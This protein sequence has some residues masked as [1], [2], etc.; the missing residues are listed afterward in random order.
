LTFFTLFN[1][2]R[3][4][5]LPEDENATTEGVP[6]VNNSIATRARLTAGWLLSLSLATGAVAADILVPQDAGTI[7]DAIA[8]AQDGDRV[9]VAPGTYR[10]RIDFLGKNITVEATG[11]AAVT[12]IDGGGEVGHVVT[13][14]G[15]ETRDAV[16]RGFTI[17]GGFGEAGSNGAGPGGG[18]LIDAASPTLE[19]CVIT[20]NAGIL[21]G[22][23][24]A[25][26]GDALIRNT[27]FADNTGLHGGALY[28]EGGALTV[29]QSEFATNYATNYGGAVAAFWQA[30]VTLTDTDFT[31]NASGQFGG[32]FY[33]VHATVD[34]ARVTFLENGEGQFDADGN[35]WQLNTLGGG[36]VYTSNTSGRIEA[37]RFLRNLAAFGSSIYVAGSGTLEVVNTLIAEGPIGIPFY[38]NASSPVIVNSTIA[39]NQNATVAVFTTYNAAPTVSNT[40]IVGSGSPTGGNGLTTL[41]YSLYDSEPF[42]AVIGPGNVQTTAPLLDPLADYTPL[43]GSPAI[44]AGDNTAVPAGITTD[45][46]GNLRFVDDPDTPDS[47]NGEAPLVDIGAIEFGSWTPELDGVTTSAGQTPMLALGAVH[48][49]PNPFN[50]RTEIR[51]TL[52]R[53]AEVRVDILDVRGRRV[54]SLQPGVLTAGAQ[55]LSWDG[56]DRD[57]RALSS[58]LYFA[59]VQAAGLQQTVKLTLAR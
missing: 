13:F 27:R 14:T 38:A 7:Q 15:G 9:L 54:G 53:E 49:A 42:A 4:R 48:A 26:G 11:G 39:D 44:D 40:I 24:S 41:N 59:V 20:G 21:G 35:S 10:E 3:V 50:P 55:A 31:G 19:D 47:G 33:A 16:L 8:I 1:R 23:L 57:G 29:E 30:D 2:P 52:G 32:A 12:V 34:L 5:T 18:I 56:T 28:V 51:F 6:D 22:G 37:A 46:L 45:L 25:T 17:T 58:G 36:G 43:P